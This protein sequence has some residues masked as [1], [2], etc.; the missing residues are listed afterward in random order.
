MIVEKYSSPVLTEKLLD[1]AS[2]RELICD[3]KVTGDLLAQLDITRFFRSSD[4]QAW[5]YLWNYREL[6]ETMLYEQYAIAKDNLFSGKITSLGELLMTAEYF[7]GNGER[8]SN[9]R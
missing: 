4:S 2:W 3:G 9:N 1:G 7:A 8:R 6:N 5:E